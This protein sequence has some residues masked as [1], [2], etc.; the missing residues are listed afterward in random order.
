MLIVCGFQRFTVT[1]S[2]I[3][4]S[5]QFT[6]SVENQVNDLLADSVVTT[7]VVV[8]CVFLPGDQLLRVEQLAVGSC[9]HLIC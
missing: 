1:K 8:G 4:Q 2:T 9:P 3:S 5:Y 6:N 7:S